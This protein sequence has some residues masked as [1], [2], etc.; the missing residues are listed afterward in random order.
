MNAPAP[1][2]VARL[3]VSVTQTGQRG[4][5]RFAVDT[6]GPVHLSPAEAI[7][8]LR[9]AADDFEQ[10]LE[11][12]LVPQHTPDRLRRRVTNSELRLDDVE[13]AV[14]DHETI[15]LDLHRRTVRVDL[16][17]SRILAHLGIPDV[18]E[19]DVDAAIDPGDTDTARMAADIRGFHRG[20]APVDEFTAAIYN[21][22]QDHR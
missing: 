21:D 6:I 11:P 18:T 20:P 14:D 7:R 16:A 3:Q 5:V 1:E 19:A 8:V 4:Q 12:D 2:P 15:L 10:H 22:G 13:E 9:D 17:F